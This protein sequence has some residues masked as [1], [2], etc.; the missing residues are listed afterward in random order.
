MKQNIVGRNQLVLAIHPTTKGFGWVLFEGPELLVDWGIATVH[1]DKNR[2]SIKKAKTLLDK[3]KPRVLVLEEYES[4]SSRRSQR[5]QK[6][7]R[8]LVSLAKKKGIKVKVLTRADVSNHFYGEQDKTRHE[9]ALAVLD[10]VEGLGHKLPPVRKPWM[11][12]DPR[13][14]L[15]NAAALAITHFASLHNR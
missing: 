4:I 5:I 8:S 10:C 7:C 12:E 1:K 9:I 13:M 11:S 3:Y 2:D 15:F 6:L 14:G